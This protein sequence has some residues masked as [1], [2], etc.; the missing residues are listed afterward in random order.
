M[1]PESGAVERP[2]NQGREFI[3]GFGE[4]VSWKQNGLELFITTTSVNN[5]VVTITN[6]LY[7]T[8]DSETIHVSK[9][10][11]V[12]VPRDRGLQGDGSQ[13]EN[14][15]VHIEATEE[16]IVY[17]NNKL[18][19]SADSFLALPVDIFGTEYYIPSYTFGE[20]KKDQARS[21]FSIIG[22]VDNTH[23]QVTVEDEVT[24]KNVDY[25]PGQTFSLI[26]NRF[27]VAQV[28]GKT[29]FKD[30]T[31][32]HVESD[33]PIGI[34]SGNRRTVVGSG[35][36]T[37]HIEE[38]VPP[39]S[40]WGK[41]YITAPISERTIGD[42]FRI[43]GSVANTVVEV[44]DVG[45][46]LTQY[47]VNAGGFIHL[48][49]PST[50]YYLIRG[51]EQ[52][53]VTQFAKSHLKNESVDSDPFMLITIPVEQW[54]NFYTIATVKGLNGD[55]DNYINILAKD[56]DRAG[57]IINNIP[58]VNIHL[59]TNWQQ[60]GKSEY[61]AAVHRVANGTHTIA[62]IDPLAQFCV[63]SYGHTSFE[64]Y[65]YAGGMRISNLY[66]FC[67]P[68]AT[69]SGDGIDNDCD[70]K[71]DEELPNGIDDDGD[72]DIDEDLAEI[73]TFT[74]STTQPTTTTT[75]TQPTTTTTTQPTT[76]TTTTQPTTTTTTKP[77]TTTTTTQPTTTATMKP[78]TTTT[79][80][81]TTTT[82][83]ESTRT[84]TTQPTTTTTTAPQTTTTTA[85]STTSIATQPSTTPPTQPATNTTPHTIGIT[86]T[87]PTTT[88]ETP[89]AETTT[90]A[91]STLT[92]TTS[93]TT[94]QTIPNA[95][96]TL[97]KTVTTDQ[98]AGATE[99]SDMIMA[100]V[101]AITAALALLACC[102]WGFCL[103]ARKRKQKQ[104][105]DDHNDSPFDC[106]GKYE[107]TKS[108]PRSHFIAWGTTG[109]L[110]KSDSPSS[111]PA[112]PLMPWATRLISAS[113]I[114]PPSRSVTPSAISADV[115][116]VCWD[117]TLSPQT[118]TP[119]NGD[120]NIDD[121]MAITEDIEN[122]WD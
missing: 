85:Q 88:T 72:G 97:S 19:H 86:T 111:S 116:D 94:S 44:T 2:D 20:T 122:D 3:L 109:I 14:K 79:T 110:T 105:K 74:T 9:G 96:V 15:G 82:T 39:V 108:P 62:H 58:I 112:P 102:C 34:I 120:A 37:D 92:A 52:I 64:S 81:S 51:S 26:V 90:T 80:E 83:M 33:K 84:T 70:N 118:S 48:D 13:I 8:E 27:Q 6:P 103:A 35:N 114:F 1:I 43:S 24:W 117:D 5:V 106:G 59:H 93:T 7:S 10:T 101:M 69:V 100:I 29:A 4:N 55:Y 87:K 42:L 22:S 40:A 16:V 47:T 17:V 65:G 45:G 121:D 50:E 60:V 12:M 75:T 104:E 11:I 78:T 99:H 95:S 91:L 46:S 71:I 21:Q 67:T 41:T 113:S 32:T 38:M 25:L 18:S 57:L 23:V 36:S 53:L 30:L 76:T 54:E 66:T 89:P 115:C 49:V 28:Q 31:G 73:T 63:L 107:P 119:T 77:T 61:Y 68:S 98:R 56:T